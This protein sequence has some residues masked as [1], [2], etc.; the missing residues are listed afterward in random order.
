[1]GYP[2]KYNTSCF[3]YLFLEKYTLVI[4]FTLNY[5]ISR[6]NYFTSC[7]YGI[8]RS[9]G[10]QRQ[11]NIMETVVCEIRTSKYVCT[12][13]YLKP[14]SCWFLMWNWVYNIWSARGHLI[15]HSSDILKYVYTIKSH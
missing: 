6:G 3:S 8:M 10:K 1:M 15:M 5:F 7:T 13:S 14:W 11:H 9:T 4:V 12:C 2:D